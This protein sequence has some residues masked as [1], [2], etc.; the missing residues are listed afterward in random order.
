MVGI[1]IYN[2][3]FDP[4]RYL[5]TVQICP[6]HTLIWLL[7]S[8]PYIATCST[9]M[10]DYCGSSGDFLKYVFAL[11]RLWLESLPVHSCFGLTLVVPYLYTL[12]P[13]HTVLV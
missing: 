9:N 12:T 2:L 6:V 5:D 7:W 10:Y 13:N 4:G 1:Q 11:V 8:S 3:R